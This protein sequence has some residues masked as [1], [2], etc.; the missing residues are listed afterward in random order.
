MIDALNAAAARR[1]TPCGTGRMVWRIWNAAAGQP[2]LL[3]HGGNGSWRHWIHTIPAF[4]ATRCVIAPDLPGLG[5]SDLPPDPQ[6][7]ASIA[8][9]VA[10]GL[11]AITTRPVDL[12]GFSFGANVGG[13]AAARLGPA[14]RSALLVG[15]GA[16]GTAR[17]ETPLV[18]VRDK[19][20][21][22]RVA[23]HRHNLASLMI[24][25]PARIDDLA[26]AIQEWNTLHARFRSRGFT[27]L[28]GLARALPDI[29]GP[30]AA[31][32]GAEDQVAKAT[33]DARIAALRAARPEAPVTLVPGAG[34]WVAYEAPAAF[35]AALAAWL[36]R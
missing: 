33:L 4:A 14:V 1:E 7:P 17:G 19:E 25:D 34:H 16:L 5:E 29:T 32:W 15:A 3:L 18:K 26:L 35:N 23:A 22:A 31:L 20:G 36:A 2:L 30:V 12:A 24:A 13:Q 27:T 28:D 21:A 8:A 10:A 9:M 11:P 6:E